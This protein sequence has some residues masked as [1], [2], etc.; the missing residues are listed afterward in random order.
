MLNTL[1]NKPVEI[2]ILG[3]GYIGLPLAVE[4]AKHAPVV[5]FD[6]ST[7]RVAELRRGEDRTLE[8]TSEILKA[9]KIKFTTTVTDLSAYNVFIVAVPTPI[10]IHKRPDLS[11]LIKASET[12]AQVL[13]LGDV[14]IYES[15]VYPG[16]TEEECVPVLEKFSGLK[17]NQDFFVGYS[18][19]RA[20][21]GD[22][23]HRLGNITKVVSGSTPAVAEFVKKLY[24]HVVP[25]GTYMVSS[26]KVAEAAKIIENIQ[27]DL[28]IGL[29]NELAIIFERLGLDTNEVINAAATKWNFHKF[30]PGLV[31]GHCIGVDPY[32]LTHKAQELGYHPEIIL[33]GRR[34]NDSMGHYIADRVVKLMCTKKINVVGAK[35]LVLGLTFKENCPDL[36]NTKVVDLINTLQSYNAYVDVYD[37][38]A[39]PE[40]ALEYYQIEL[41]NQLQLNSYD[42]IVLAVPHREILE[43]GAAGLKQLGKPNSVLFDL[44]SVLERQYVD[45]RL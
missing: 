11:P 25:K 17:F 31:G 18:P 21:P 28:N 41:C 38:L 5:G 15:T 10:D 8:V 12:I 30:I 4:F 22:H 29:M 44:K 43:L 23:E 35:I 24:D 39:A 34:L 3:L 19:E 37:P 14:V 36:R 45:A 33:A 20:N 6:V 27:R 16:A 40:K 26:I 2:A 13:K 32:Y 9:I 7:A 42:A 1:S